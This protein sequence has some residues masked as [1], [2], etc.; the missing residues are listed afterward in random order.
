MQKKPDKSYGHIN[1]EFQMKNMSLVDYLKGGLQIQTIVAIDYSS[2]ISTYSIFSIVIIFACTRLLH[3]DVPSAR[4]NRASKT[5]SYA[6]VFSAYF[7]HEAFCSK[8][9]LGWES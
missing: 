7:P 9:L 4:M 2:K 3:L 1:I 6:K 8:D 5:S